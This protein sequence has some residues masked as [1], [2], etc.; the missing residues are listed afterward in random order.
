MFVAL[1][2]ASASVCAGQARIPNTSAETMTTLRRA[3]VIVT[4]FDSQESPLL[5]G[6]GFFISADIVV[7]NQHVVKGAGLIKLEMFGGA[8]RTVQKVLAVDEKDDLALLQLETPEVN[9]T[10]LRLADSATVEGE[11]IVVMGNPQPWQ[12]KLTQ[13]E[14]GPTWQFKSTGKRIQISAS[15]LPG[16]SGAPVVNSEGQV[17]GIAALHMAGSDDL[18]FAVPVE[19][20]RAL[21]ASS[22]VAILRSSISAQ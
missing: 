5:Q 14:V 20:L 4:T 9:V 21:R 2:F 8:T 6:S 10:I 3:V 15:I 13:G 19:S 22:R 17:V 7:T 1:L 18:N 12:W 16:S 11:S